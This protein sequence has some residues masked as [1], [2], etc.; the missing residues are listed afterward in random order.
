MTDRDD[1]R[2]LYSPSLSSSSAVAHY[3]YDKKGGGLSKYFLNYVSTPGFSEKVT[4]DLLVR[5][6]ADIG[7]FNEIDSS[8]RYFEDI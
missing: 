6:D 4:H 5:L 3:R 8:Q 2:R 1:Q 7:R